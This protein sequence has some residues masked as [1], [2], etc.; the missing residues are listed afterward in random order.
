[1]MVGQKIRGAE[2]AKD[3]EGECRVNFMHTKGR[4][5]GSAG[6]FHIRNETTEREEV[7]PADGCQAREVRPDWVEVSLREGLEPD[8]QGAVE[9][10][11]KSRTER[12]ERQ[13][14]TAIQE[15]EPSLIRVT[16]EVVLMA[17]AALRRE[18]VGAL[19]EGLV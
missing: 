16:F 19:P 18:D 15:R 13:P 4:A 6:N 11:A 3:Q 2:A 10:P 8:L 12:Q 9:R 5:A 1:G 17:A 14:H 7:I